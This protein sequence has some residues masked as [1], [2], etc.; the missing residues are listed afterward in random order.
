MS[1]IL[2][3]APEDMTRLHGQIGVF[4]LQRLHAGHLIQTD[5]TLSLSGSFGCREIEHT[6]LMNLLL[7]LC[8]LHLR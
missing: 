2:E 8:I 7:P 1:D 6:S 3:L 5:R 4:A